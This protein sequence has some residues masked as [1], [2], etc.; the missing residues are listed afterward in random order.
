MT[1]DI[2]Y[3]GASFY[4]AGSTWKNCGDTP[5]QTGALGADQA[6]QGVAKNAYGQVLGTNMTLMNNLTS[7]LGSII[8]G[9]PGQQGMSPTE[10]ASE[11]SQAINQAAAANKNVQQAIGENAAK[12]TATPGIESGITQ[13]ERAAA[14]TNI[15]NQLGNTEA[16][17][18]QKNYDIGR[19]NYWDS[20]KAMLAAPAAFE[21]PATQAANVVNTANENVD[22]QANANAQSSTGTEL[23]GLGEAAAKDAATTFAG[24]CWIAA[25]V[26][27]GWDDPRVDMARNFIFNVW[28]KESVIGYLVAK[29]YKKVGER[30]ARIVKCS[31]ILR[32]IFKPLFDVAV[33]KNR[34]S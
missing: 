5:G 25:A 15:E 29:L 19:Q 7:S 28:A 6:F 32:R 4:S 17:I 12:G 20:S 24:A 3:I 1:S 10:L 31:S 27:D 8:S 16:G 30:V 11:N 22:T 13:A 2:Q 21:D 14:S 33:R 26:Y 9:G 34:K 23:L 18:T